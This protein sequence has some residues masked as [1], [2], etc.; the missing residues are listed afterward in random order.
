MKKFRTAIFTSILIFCLSALII[1]T[2]N[3]A[4]SMNLNII[5]QSNFD[6]AIKNT[7]RHE[8]GLSDNKNDSG[9]WTRYGI[10]LRFLKQSHIDPN[11][12]GVENSEDI[13]HLTLTEAD[14]IYYNQ[15]WLKGHYDKI[16][17]INVAAHL[18]DFGVNAGLSQSS[19]LAK[20]SINRILN[21]P[22][23]VDGVLDNKTIQIIN[24]LVPSIF[25]SS[26]KA[27]EEDFY[28][29]IV[30]RHPQLKCFL[31]GWLNRIND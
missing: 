24:H 21:Q 14:N 11:G 15:F 31:K 13:I 30:K 26:L 27:E 17:N 25:L 5:K 10:S 2:S 16:D 6:Y 8:G 22:I 18:F 3:S 12:D 20:R 23:S 9:S 7:L 29:E 1:I 19:K 4:D 28:L